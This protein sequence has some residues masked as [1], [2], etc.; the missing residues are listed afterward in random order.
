MKAPSLC[1]GRGRVLYESWIRSVGGSV[2]ARY[3]DLACGVSGRRDG[4]ATM[5]VVCGYAILPPLARNCRSIASAMSTP[6]TGCL[7]YR[8]ARSN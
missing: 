8:I 1:L 7:R 2:G 3:A 5:D 6:R 4:T